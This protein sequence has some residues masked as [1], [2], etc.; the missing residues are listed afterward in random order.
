MEFP[1]ISNWNSKKLLAR[2]SKNWND[3]LNIQTSLNSE[4]LNKVKVR[5]FEE[6]VNTDNILTI[7]DKVE[8]NDALNAIINEVQQ[9]ELE[10]DKIAPLGGVWVF[11]GLEIWPK[12]AGDFGDFEF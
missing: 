8:N 3:R 5:E 1:R 4:T 6:R 10:W 7:N 12:F 9:S 2:I 11:R